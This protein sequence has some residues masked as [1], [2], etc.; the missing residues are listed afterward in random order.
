[1]SSGAPGV[2]SQLPSALVVVEPIGTPPSY[3]VTR[4]PG[5]AVP[6]ILGRVSSVTPPLATLPVTAPTS[7]STP[8]MVGLAGGT[9]STP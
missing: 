7:S 6:L 8:V 3:T 5:S 1:M 2:S 9:V 4:E